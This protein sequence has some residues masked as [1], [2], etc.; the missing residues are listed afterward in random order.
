VNS[1]KVK[2]HLSRFDNE[3][4][5]VLIPILLSKRRKNEEKEKGNEKEKRDDAK[6]DDLK[7]ILL[8]D[9]SKMSN[10]SNINYMNL[11]E[12]EGK[13]I[14]N[15]RF[16]DDEEKEG[17]E[18]KEGK[19]KENHE[20]DEENNKNRRKRSLRSNNNEENILEKFISTFL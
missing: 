12:D 4:L 17:K 19:V 20:N 15:C 2:V 16:D 6:F 3:K 1:D 13:G 18:G 5:R 7:Y 11:K 9:M 8:S 14:D 10:I